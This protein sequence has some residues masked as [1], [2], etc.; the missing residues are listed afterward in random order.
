M[1]KIKNQD[2]TIYETGF[3]K[4]KQITSLQKKELPTLIQ[5]RKEANYFSGF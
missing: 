5:M 4:P 3:C 1:Y 2:K